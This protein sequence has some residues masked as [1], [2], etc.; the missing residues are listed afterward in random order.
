MHKNRIITASAVVTLALAGCG[1]GGDSNK[2][3]SY[4]A[5]SSKANDICQKAED[6][7][8]ALGKTTTAEATPENGELI[9][10][11]VG[12]VEKQRDDLED[13][14]APD[15]LEAA[16]EEFIKLTNQQID[17]AKEAQTAAN[18]KDQQG[19]ENAI[20]RLQALSSQAN[21]AGE[22]LGAPACA[23]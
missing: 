14:N 20:T 23:S 19:Y 11:L 17:I 1:G 6:D 4:S 15:Q 22:Q 2:K 9:G 21:A 10:K 8:K 5:F 7:N 16:Q 3:L 18:A 12:F 13:L